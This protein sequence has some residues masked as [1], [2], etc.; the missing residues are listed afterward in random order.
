MPAIQTNA[1]EFLLTSDYPLDKIVHLVE[2]SVTV[3]G[4]DKATTTKPHGLPYAPLVAGNYSDLSDFSAAY[5][6]K[7]GPLA[8]PNPISPYKY[9]FSAYSDGTNIIIESGNVVSTS[10]VTLYYRLYCFAPSDQNLESEPT[11]QGVD[12]FMLNTDFNYTKLA[13][14]DVFDQAANTSFDPTFHVVTH[15][16]GY[17]PQ[18]SFWVETDGIIRNNPIASPTDR[19]VVC[20]VTSTSLVFSFISTLASRVHYRVYHDE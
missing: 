19:G 12:N 18:V 7:S 16:L 13:L 14:A 2:G 3:P 5:E 15:N 9:D 8:P 4:T 10:A 17:I 11:N 20:N 1:R 6:F